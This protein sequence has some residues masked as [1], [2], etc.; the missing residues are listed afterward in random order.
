M[1]TNRVERVAPILKTPKDSHFRWFLQ[2]KWM[3]HK[4]ELLEWEKKSPD[5]DDKYYFQQ[6]KWVL[7]RMFKEEQKYQKQ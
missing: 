4:D 5:Y 3:E 1:L 7:K 2:R 6:Y